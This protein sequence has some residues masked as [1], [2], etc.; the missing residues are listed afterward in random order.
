MDKRARDRIEEYARQNTL[1]VGHVTGVTLGGASVRVEGSGRYLRNVPALQ[2]TELVVGAEVILARVGRGGWVI[3]GATEQGGGVTATTANSVPVAA[4]Q[5]TADTDVGGFALIRWTASYFDVRCYEIMVNTSES[6]SGATT[7]V[8]DNSWLA[9]HGAN[10]TYYFKVR[11]VGPNWQRSSWTAWNSFTISAIDHGGL[12][13]LADDDHTQYLLADGSRDLTGNMAVDPGITIDGVDISAHASRHDQGGADPLSTVPDH[14]HSGD[15]GDGAQL[16]HGD[17]DGLDGD[18]HPQY[19]EIAQAEAITGEWDFQ[20]DVTQTAGYDVYPAGNE[21]GLMARVDGGRVWDEH[22]DVAALPGGWGWAGAP[23]ATPAVIDYSVASRMSCSTLGL[24]RC[25][26]FK[27]ID[28]DMSYWY[29]EV[30]SNARAVGNY[31]GI[32]IDDGTDNNYVEMRVAVAAYPPTQWRFDFV[33][34]TG[35]GAVNVTNCN[36]VNAPYPYFLGIQIS[37]T[38]WT[39]WAA[40]GHAMG[41]IGAFPAGDFWAGSV[42]GLAWTPARAGWIM[43]NADGTWWYNYQMD[44]FSE[45]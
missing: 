7:Y 31:W 18:D 38:K 42:L 17:L 10:D 13:G 8:V 19:A 40:W 15:A 43:C 30:A 2:G 32:R 24:N 3:L 6:E 37:G 27:A 35:G 33:E 26:L 28:L 44:A 12:A 14:D 11:A 20:A 1:V 25:F 22:F 5:D 4:P 34:R 9:Y 21:M 23:F 39:D 16:D 29:A 36:T 45:E 41:L